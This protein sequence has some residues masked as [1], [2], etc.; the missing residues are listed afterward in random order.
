MELVVKRLRKAFTLV[1]LLV[2]IGI[3]AILIAILLPALNRARE[4][5]YTIKC[6]ASM[7]QIGNAFFMYANDWKGTWPV[8]KMDLPANTIYKWGRFN[9][10]PINNSGGGICD[11]YWFGMVGH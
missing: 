6:S 4:Q 11:E 2:V 10:S 3:I 7:K 1:E 8:V 9:F 5:A